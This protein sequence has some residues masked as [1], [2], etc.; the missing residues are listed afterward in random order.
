[1]V[2]DNKHHL[3]YFNGS[4]HGVGE[5]AFVMKLIPGAR[6]LQNPEYYYRVLGNLSHRL[7]KNVG[8]RKT[9]VNLITYQSFMGDAVQD[10]L[11]VLMTSS[12]SKVLLF[13][14]GY[15]GNGKETVGASTNGRI[16]SFSSGR[17]DEFC[18]WACKM[19]EKITDDRITTED[20]I[21]GTIIP[22]KKLQRY[23]IYQFF[24]FVMG[25]KQNLRNVS[26]ITVLWWMMWITL[27][28]ILP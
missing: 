7:I 24:L 5:D 18:E 21:R 3:C 2:V 10:S 22:K 6:T 15:H 1:M 20:I 17:L 19:G 25:K 8:L 16:W 27:F 13:G 23:Q 12:S 4:V 28:G 26:Q 11:S 9:P 14:V